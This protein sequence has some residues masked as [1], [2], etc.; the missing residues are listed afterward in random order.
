MHESITTELEHNQ[1]RHINSD[2][3]RLSPMV[4][5]YIGDK[6]E[7]LDS[8]ALQCGHTPLIHFSPSSQS[9]VSLR[10]DETR[11]FRERFGGV[12]KVQKARIIGIIVGSIHR[13]V[14]SRHYHPSANSVRSWWP[15]DYIH[16]GRL[17]EAKLCNFPEVDLFCLISNEDTSAA[18]PKHSRCP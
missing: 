13:G 8:I 18:A 5:I 9:C 12:L 7:Q 4:I 17:N 10:G 2:L 16:H 11:A 3:G 14:H 1:R 6:S 15:E